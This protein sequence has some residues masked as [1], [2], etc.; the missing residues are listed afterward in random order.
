MLAQDRDRSQ[1]EPDC[2]ATRD[3]RTPLD[4]WSKN[5]RR[6]AATLLL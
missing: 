2:P 6:R 4:E 5:Q 3:D 1:P